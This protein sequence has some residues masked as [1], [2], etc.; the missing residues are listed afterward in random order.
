MAQYE[1][2]SRLHCT[3]L[4]GRGGGAIEDFLLPLAGPLCK[5]V[6]PTRVECSFECDLAIPKPSNR[7]VARAVFTV[8]LHLSAKGGRRTRRKTLG[9][10]LYDARFGMPL[11]RL[12]FWGAECA[13]LRVENG[14]AERHRKGIGYAPCSCG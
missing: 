8:V 7:P 4:S 11:G 5:A 1:K 9:V 12:L 6:C 2:L 10:S 3:V 14:I 13:A